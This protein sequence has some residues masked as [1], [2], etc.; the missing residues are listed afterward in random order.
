MA[1]ASGASRAV[2]KDSTRKPPEVLPPYPDAGGRF[3]IT[4]DWSPDGRSIGISGQGGGVWLYSLE[5]RT[6]RRVADGGGPHWLSDGRRL[7]FQNRGRLFIADVASGATRDVLGIPGE[8]LM[9]PRLAADDSQLFF[10]RQVADGDIWIV[11]FD[12]K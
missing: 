10:L 9:H 1:A 11:R 8:I 7:V 6:Y 5:T 3:P 4:F 12:G 2:Q